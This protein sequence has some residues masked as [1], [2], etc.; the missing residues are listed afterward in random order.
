MG[1]G[2]TG[3][4]ALGQGSPP[5]ISGIRL[6]LQVQVESVVLV[7]LVVAVVVGDG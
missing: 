2:G 6:F 1:E 5:G 7:G 3:T 4:R